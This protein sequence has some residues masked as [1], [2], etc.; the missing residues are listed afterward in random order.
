[1]KNDSNAP[2]AYS[3]RPLLKTSCLLFK[4]RAR[5]FLALAVFS[6]LL[7]SHSSF[8]QSIGTTNGITVFPPSAL[9]TSSAISTAGGILGVNNLSDVANSQTSWNNLHGGEINLC[10]VTGTTAGSVQCYQIV[11]GH[12]AKTTCYVNGY[13]N[14]GA[15]AQTCSLTAN[16]GSAFARAGNLTSN[17]SPFPATLTGSPPSAISLP[18]SMSA[19]ESGTLIAEGQ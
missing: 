12:Y 17:L 16:G 6:S 2:T 19:A 18:T 3:S 10:T 11:E 13:Q 4:E 8:A 5:D 9:I 1:V 15:T 7:L 14:S